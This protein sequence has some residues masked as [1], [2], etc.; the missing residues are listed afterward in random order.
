MIFSV[1]FSVT[2]IVLIKSPASQT[3]GEVV[4]TES[5]DSATAEQIIIENIANEATSHVAEVG[6]RFL[7][8]PYT[9]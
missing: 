8:E 4:R 5:V 6:W 3:E 9:V 1:A 7:L 2:Y